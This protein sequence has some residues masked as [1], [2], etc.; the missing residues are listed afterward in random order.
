MTDMRFDG[1]GLG[2]EGTAGANE[3]RREK[4]GY[5]GTQTFSSRLVLDTLS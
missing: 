1:W 2:G 3:K 5:E 4:E